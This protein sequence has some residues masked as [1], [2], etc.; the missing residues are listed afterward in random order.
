MAQILDGKKLAAH[1]EEE[2]R[3]EVSA[4]VEAYGLSPCLAAILVGDD[5]R[6]ALYVRNKAR[7]AGRVGIR[8][9]TFH[10]PAQTTQ[11]ELLEVMET[12]NRREDVHGILPQMP[13]PPHIDPA[14]VF[15]RIDPRKDVD[16]LSP[17]NAGR[18]A[19]GR[20]QLVP[21]T[22]RGI[23]ALIHKTG[24]DLGGAHAVVVGRSNLVGKP[25]AQLLLSADATVTVCHSR[26]KDLAEYTRRADVL[27]VAAGRPR[28]VTAE[29]VKPGA[30]VI[31][32][33]VHREGDR[34]VGDVDFE[35][36]REVAGWITPVPGGVGPMTIAML[37]K[38]TLE[39]ARLQVARTVPVR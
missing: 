2:V 4:F 16:G 29:M 25:T 28:L 14:A 39:A 15:E 27:V 36:V 9:E 37:L 35:G 13:L 6:S 26:T 19:L 7:A 5:P 31:D 17:Y 38:N 12:L 3:R 22:P 34:W 18:L 11:A 1:V 33:G 20:A 8:S 23:L 32:V 21:C 30:V 24:I 10:L